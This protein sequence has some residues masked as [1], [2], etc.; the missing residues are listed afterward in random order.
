[1]IGKPTPPLQGLKVLDLTRLLPGP[2]CTMHLADLG[3]DVIK[4]EDTGAGD[5]A[6]PAM[7]AILHRNKRA[8]QLD[9]KQPAGTE[10]FLTLARDADVIIESFRP[11]VV[12]RL[13]IAYATVARINPRIVYCSLTGYGQ[14][15]PLQAM[16]GHDINYCGL[17]GVSS[18]IGQAPDMLAQ[19]NVPIADL[20]GGAMNA[21]MG[22]LA[23]LY[24]VQRNGR[25]RHVDVAMADGALA[26]MLMPLATLARL[27]HTQPAGQD[28]LSGALPCYGHYPTSDGQHL[29]VGALERKFWDSFCDVLQREDLKGSHR[30]ADVEVS[31]QVREE[32]ARLIAAQ[33]LAY[34]EERF[35]NVDCCVT[36]VLTLEQALKNEHFVARGMV[37]QTTHPSYGN[38]TQFGCPVK[39]TDFEFSVS[40]PAPLPGEH[41]GEILS[42]AG[43]SETHISSLRAAGVTG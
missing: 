2:A 26:N 9:L 3:A 1:M 18:Q 22:I 10:A 30:S 36:P 41:S 24:D 17:A 21:V 15:G 42:A 43:L 20:M 13:G 14:D 33:P 40:R 34:W 38:V 19:S 32:I 8:M 27:G 39:M 12:D 25:G 35:A 16:A 4:I 5:Y 7:R 31:R 37:L 6:P 11:G 29:A 23:A 28:T